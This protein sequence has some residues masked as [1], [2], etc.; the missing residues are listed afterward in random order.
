MTKRFVGRKEELE[1][2]NDLIQKKSASLI[3][4]QGRRRIGKSRL[5]EEFAKKYK[6]IEISALAPS[7]NTSADLQRFAFAQQLSKY[8]PIDK[9]D[10]SDWMPI[11]SFLAQHVAQGRYVILFDE[12]SWMGSCDPDFIAKLKNAWDIEFKY[13]PQ[14]IMVLCG[15]VSIWIQ[16]HIIQSTAFLGRLSLTLKLN[17]LSLEECNE[18]LN[19]IGFVKQPHERLKILSITG[20]IPRYLEEIKPNKT[21]DQ[22]IIDLCFKKSG[23]LFTEFTHIFTDIFGSKNT[24]YADVLRALVGSPQESSEISKAIGRPLGGN[25]SIMM[26]NLLVAGF[27]ERDFTWQIKTGSES[28]LSHYRLSDN[29]IRFYLKY[30]EPAK[31]KIEKDMFAPS[32]IDSLPGFHSI[33]GLQFENLMLNNRLL[34]LKKINLRPHDI[35]YDNPYFQKGTLNQKGC[36][37]DYLI[38]LKTQVLY[39]CEFKFSKDKIGLKVIHEMK[40]KLN[41][42]YLPKR[43]AIIPVLVCVNGVTEQALDEDYFYHVIDISDVLEG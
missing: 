17:E 19:E 35:I 8:F 20:G 30:I 41:H 34:L 33:M 28:K 24:F 38:Q 31:S 27:I 2:L 9:L 3:T 11:F 37:I 15:S 40:E 13:N 32:G 10:S 7:K 39:A 12:I 18:F 14:L 6:F 42:L 16:E 4:I 5:V 26:N 22:N 43:F 1:L 29:Y 36:Q 21:A 23:I 25:F